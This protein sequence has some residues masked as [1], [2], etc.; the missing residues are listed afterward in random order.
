MHD[1]DCFILYAFVDYYLL[2]NS[3]IKP[4]AIYASSRCPKYIGIY[5]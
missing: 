4:L 1:T 2:I 5:L 3:S